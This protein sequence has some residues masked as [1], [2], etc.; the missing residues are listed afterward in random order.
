MFKGFLSLSLTLSHPHIRSLSFTHIVRTH[1]NNQPT[2]NNNNRHTISS[3]VWWVFNLKM[4]RSSRFNHA[5][6]HFQ[7]FDESIYWRKEPEMTS[8]R[9]QENHY[10]RYHNFK[11]IWHIA[12]TDSSERRT[13]S[14]PRWIRIF[15]T[16]VCFNVL[17]SPS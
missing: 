17:K 6:Q 13:H 2:N 7:N 12:R 8:R 10:V 14:T 9:N 1:N 3:H 15:F 4:P 5:Q 11:L 16:R